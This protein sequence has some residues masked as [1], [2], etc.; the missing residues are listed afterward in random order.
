MRSARHGPRQSRCRERGFG[1]PL[2]IPWLSIDGTT[3]PKATQDLVIRA[4]RTNG[5]GFCTDMDSKDAAH[6][7][8]TSV[9]VNTGGRRSVALPGERRD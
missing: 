6:A 8:E 9:R 5:C 3:V 7:G 4:S 1:D 2:L